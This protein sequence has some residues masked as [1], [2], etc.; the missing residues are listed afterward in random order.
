V[1]GELAGAPC[2]YHV[3]LAPL[4]EQQAEHGCWT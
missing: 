2:Q 3:N 4:L 1:L